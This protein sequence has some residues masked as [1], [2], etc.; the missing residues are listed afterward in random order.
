MAEVAEITEKEQVML[1][2]ITDLSTQ[3]GYPPSVRELANE[4]GLTRGTAH[5]MLMVL[6]DK[7]VVTW[8]PDRSARTLRVIS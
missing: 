1:E 7:G 8:A 5:R 3:Y 2:A 4:L 6:R